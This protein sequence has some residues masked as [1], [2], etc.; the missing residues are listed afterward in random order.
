MLSWCIVTPGYGALAAEKLLVTGW[1]EWVRLFPGDIVV[2]AKLD[3]GAK[4]PS[5][6]ARGV[7][8]YKKDGKP[9][10]KFRFTNNA[11][12][13]IVMDR[14]V[15]KNA[16]IKDLSGPSHRRPVVKLGICLGDRY[17]ITEVNL[18][19]RSRFNFRLLLGRRFLG[20]ASIA[21]N[22]NRQY[23]VMPTCQK[24]EEP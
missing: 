6:D 11:G 5:I 24:V 7:K 3:T 4:T 19:D 13:S 8:L 18:Y 20:P 21:V 17:L 9:W 10:A 15:V 16:R 22:A 1:S 12:E 2:K 14:P 23:T